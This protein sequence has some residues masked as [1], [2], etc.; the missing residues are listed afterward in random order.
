MAEVLVVFDTL[1]WGANRRAY[2]VQVCGRGLRGDRW[3]GWIEFLPVD[4]R[5]PMRTACETVQ[6][7]RADLMSW[8]ERLTLVYLDGA[9]ARALA[10]VQPRHRRTDIPATPAFA[11]PASPRPARGA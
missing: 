3:E 11:G 2:T 4:G 10:L 5:P 1:I 8:A 6:P 9:L 7:S